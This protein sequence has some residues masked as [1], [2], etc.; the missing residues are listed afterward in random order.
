MNKQR[1]INLI[2]KKW[3]CVK[4]EVE[5]DCWVKYRKVLKPLLKILQDNED[6]KEQIKQIINNMFETDETPTDIE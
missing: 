1:N 3:N 6:D 4:N 2:K 5:A